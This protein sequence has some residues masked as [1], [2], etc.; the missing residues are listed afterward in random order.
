[1]LGLI[2]PVADFN[3]YPHYRSVPA[4]HER[5][6]LTAGDLISYFGASG[7]GGIEDE[8]FLMSRKGYSPFPI[9]TMV[10]TP[11]LEVYAPY[12]DLMKEVKAGFGRTMSHLPAV[13]GVSRQTLYNWLNGE[14]PKKQ[15]QGRLV[16]LAAAA[17]VFI[18]A[19][20]KPTAMSLDRTV[21]QGQSFIELVGQGADGAKTA[22][23]LLRIEKRGTTARQKLDALLG[24]RS[25]SR[26]D[27]ADMGRPALDENV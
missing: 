20:F 14:I 17:R 16:Q 5:A 12:V 10:P 26:P 25:F 1:M 24:D 22:E 19:G 15:H 3:A 9:L 18:E 6:A 23:K 8:Q 7:T 11:S 13:F 27:V 2:V 4:I 21:A